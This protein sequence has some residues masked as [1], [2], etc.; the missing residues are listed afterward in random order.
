MNNVFEIIQ[1][2]M[3]VARGWNEMIETIKKTSFKQGDLLDISC[4]QK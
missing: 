1:K 4:L 3:S 2:K